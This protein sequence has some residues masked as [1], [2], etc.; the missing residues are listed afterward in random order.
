VNRRSLSPRAERSTAAIEWRS[1]LAI[2][3]VAFAVRALFLFA[4]PDRTWPHSIL[5]EGDA[6]AWVDWARVLGRGESFEFDLPMRTP[7]VAFL[8]HVIANGALDGPFVGLKL[9]WCAISA[10]TCAWL[11]VVVRR[12]LTPRV[13]LI[14]AGLLCF[15][16][17]QYQTATS[18]N[19][20]ALYTF[21]LVAIVE[22]T[23]RV[24]QHASAARAAMLG[25]LHGLALMLRAEHVLLLIA[26]LGYTA[27]TLRARPLREIARAPAIVAACALALCAPWIWRSHVATER[28]NTVALHEPDIAHADPPWTPQARAFFARLPAFARGGNFEFLQTLRRQAG[29]SEVTLADV[30]GFFR[31]QFGYVPEPLSEWTLSSSK[32]P[33]DFALAND[34][35][36]EGGFSRVGLLDGHDA[37]PTFA[38]GRP[39]HLKLY[40]HGYAVGWAA[41]RADFGGWLALV[42]R[43]LERFVDGATLGWTAYD[44]PYGVASV[45]RPVD[46]ATPRD[47]HWLV[48]LAVAAP[49][50]AGLVV[51]LR[52]RSAAVWLL[53]IA[54][55]LAVTVAFYG[56]ARQAVSV[57][58]AFYVLA[59]LALDALL[60]RVSP[61]SARWLGWSVVCAALACD[62]AH[63]AT[64]QPLVLEQSSSP[65]VV[66]TPQWGAGAF[67]SY[68]QL[69]LVPRTP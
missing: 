20:E 48:E 40:N 6:T 56:Y 32:G 52:R 47:A 62:V 8:L 38:F 53:A 34:R 4:S 25:V 7:G 43:K 57:A 14:A 28:F 61:S 29:A 15:S 31:E 51:A 60:A 67:E 19:N 55:K 27:W 39:S 44:L 12:E 2:A 58:P 64:A 10:A 18:L 24:A 63:F 26:L 46:L 41:I 23:Q 68:D 16:F 59:A 45:R 22:L 54:Y 1:A 9:V 13:A 50:L 11:Y 42:G 36:S 66:Q 30:E 37:D 5:Y 21:L 35:R 49:M 17:G 69:V 65:R 33:L 3:S